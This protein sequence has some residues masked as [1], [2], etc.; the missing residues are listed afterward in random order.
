MDP[1]TSSGA[2][3]YGNAHPVSS[4]GVVPERHEPAP[5]K[6]RTAAGRSLFSRAGIKEIVKDTFNEWSDD[7]GPRLGAA[8]AYY[9]VFSLAPILVISMAVAGLV[10]GHKAVH[11]QIMGELQ[12]LVGH[13][14]AVGL[15]AMLRAAHKPATGIIASALAFITLLIGATG[16]F[17]EL[18]DALNTIW[19]VKP[20]PKGT[21]WQF[22][23]SRVLGF[24]IVLGIGFLLLVSLVLS[25]ALGALGEYLSS[26]LPVSSVVLGV[27]DFV[28][29]LAVTSALF[30]MLFKILPEA[31][32]AW[33]DVWVGSVITALLFTIGK[34]AIGLYIGKTVIASSY[35]AVGSLVVLIVWLYYSAQ[36]F[37][38]GAE[39]TRVYANK[40][41][42]RL[43]PKPGAQLAPKPQQ[44]LRV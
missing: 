34:F 36:I 30:A 39:F 3:T 38:L 2:Q 18:Q 15:Q 43:A 19:E 37:Y 1:R 21:V 24:E 20:S 4:R 41:G 9:T 33:S 40:F 22:L 8:L 26:V 35:G 12:K 25:A 11:D 13:D 44:E 28:V 7:K 27:I 10:F 6:D 23:K 42:S 16:V 5:Q 32:I 31:T 29:S 17:T 14:G